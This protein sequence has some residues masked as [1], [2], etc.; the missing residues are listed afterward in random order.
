LDCEL[1]ISDTAQRQLRNIDKHTAKE[2]V[3]WL[4]KTSSKMKSPEDIEKYF[5]P[6]RGDLKGFWKKRRGDYRLICKL[7]DGQKKLVLLLVSA[8]HRCDVYE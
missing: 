1:E 6:L 5:L 8:G 7:N 4:D 3:L 2:L